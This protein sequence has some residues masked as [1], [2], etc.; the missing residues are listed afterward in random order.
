MRWLGI[1]TATFVD[2]NGVPKLVHDIKP[3]ETFPSISVISRNAAEDFDEIASRDVVYGS[4]GES[5]SYKL[6]EANIVDLFDNL[7]N[8]DTLSRVKVPR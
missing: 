3:I 2:I 1:P 5:N 8:Y 7:L 6:D 4:G